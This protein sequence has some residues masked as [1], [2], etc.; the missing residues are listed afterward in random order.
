MHDHSLC[1]LLVDGH[2]IVDG[3]L[4]AVYEGRKLVSTE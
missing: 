3:A 4:G 1:A 2:L